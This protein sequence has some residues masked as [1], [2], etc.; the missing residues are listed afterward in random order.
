L[1]ESANSGNDTYNPWREDQ[2]DDL[3]LALCLALWV[4]ERTPMG[5]VDETLAFSDDPFDLYG[6]GFVF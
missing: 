5:L 6:E 1:S 2:H 3:V 4:A